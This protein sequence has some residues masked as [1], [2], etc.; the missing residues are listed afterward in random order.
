VGV[1]VRSW[2]EASYEVIAI[3]GVADPGVMGLLADGIA[4]VADEA[5]A[6][7][8]DLDGLLMTDLAAVRAL[9]AGVLDHPVRDRLVVSCRRLSGRR[10]LRLLGGDRLRVADGRDRALALAGQ[11]GP[12]GAT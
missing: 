3:E 1:V 10:I 7:I 12:L 8:L 4:S 6:V 9:L 2:S 11:F 5:T